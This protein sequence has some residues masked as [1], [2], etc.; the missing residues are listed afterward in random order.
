MMRIGSQCKLM[1]L[2]FLCA[3]ATSQKTAFSLVKSRLAI[4]SPGCPFVRHHA[5]N[6]QI[7][8]MAADVALMIASKGDI[9]F[10]TRPGIRNN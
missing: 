6:G 9:L 5:E 1:V 3:L 8:K 7:Q 4:G 2:L 10:Q